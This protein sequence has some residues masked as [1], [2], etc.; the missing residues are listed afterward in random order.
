DRWTTGRAFTKTTIIII[1][2]TTKLRSK[3]VWKMTT[4]R[5]ETLKLTTTNNRVNGE[6]VTNT[7]AIIITTII[8]ATITT[9][10]VAPRGRFP[11][12][13]RQSPRI[14]SLSPDVRRKRNRQIIVT[15]TTIIITTTGATK[16]RNT[17]TTRG[18]DG[19]EESRGCNENLIKS[20]TGNEERRNGRESI[21]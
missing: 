20:G 5:R 10:T 19:K 18:T 16:R 11:N 3:E 6:A 1:I 8:T 12:K 13:R 9:I 2:I 7:T 21:T 17:T 4:L 15:I 14:P